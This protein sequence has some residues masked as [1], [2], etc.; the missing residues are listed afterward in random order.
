LTGRF[1]LFRLLTMEMR[2]ARSAGELLLAFV[3]VLAVLAVVDHIRTADVDLYGHILFG[4]EI[5]E[6]GEVPRLDPYSYSAP[7]SRWIDHEW[8]TELVLAWLYDWAGPSGLIVWRLVVGSLTAW[9]LYDMIGQRL[10]RLLPRWGLFWAGFASMGAFMQFRPQMVTY[11]GFAFLLWVLFGPGHGKGRWLLFFPLIMVP[12]TN[13]HGGFMAGLGLVA[14]VA[15]GRAVSAA[16]SR[17]ETR[18]T[19]K[20]VAML[21]A[22]AFAM[23]LATLANPYGLELHRSVLEQTTNPLTKEIIIEWMPLWRQ[24]AQGEN[25]G[26]IVPFFVLSVVVLLMVARRPGRLDASRWLVLVGLWLMALSSLRHVPLAALAMVA[27]CLPAA[28]EPWTKE[29]TEGTGAF[30]LALGAGLLLIVTLVGPET[31]RREILLAPKSFPVRAVRLLSINGAEGNVLAQFRWGEYVLWHLGGK[32]RVFIDQRY[33]SVYPRRVIREY[34][35]V[36]RAK[37]EAR[38]VLRAYPHDFVLMIPDKERERLFLSLG[39]KKLFEDEASSLFAF[40]TPRTVGILELFERGR[41]E[42]PSILHRAEPFP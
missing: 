38:E 39:A 37:P 42:I 41:L 13:A 21:A 20:E 8:L 18:A 23:G 40:P 25:M 24:A 26:V 9:L 2:R 16:F 32:V 4:R 3:L 19:W 33:D 35:A 14:M 10:L 5:L 27:S 1:W 34:L 7:G 6:T 28:P 31:F 15:T 12:W 11:L 30:F 22:A 36:A 29:E 17:S